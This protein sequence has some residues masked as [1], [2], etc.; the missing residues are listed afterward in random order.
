MTVPDPD[1]LPAELTLPAPSVRTFGEPRFHTEGDLAAVAFAPDDTL[2]SIDEV[3]ALVHWSTAGEV[4]KRAFLSDLETIWQFSADASRL[5]SGK[6]DLLIWDTAAGK[7]A[8][9]VATPT[10]V[11]ALAFTP[12]GARLV[13]G[14]DDG[15]VTVWDA[16]TGTGVAAFTAHPQGV[17]AAS[18]SPDGRHLATAGEDRAVC[19]WDLATRK[20]LHELRSHTDRV[21]SLSWSRDGTLFASAGWDTSA[22]VWRLGESDPVILLNSHAEQVTC[23]AFH[24]ADA[25][26]LATADSDHE[27]YLWADAT[28]GKVGHILRG[29]VDEVRSLAFSRDGKLLASAGMD[30]V[31]HL[32]DAE[33]GKLLAGPNPKGKHDTAAFT[34]NGRLMLGSTGGPTFRLWDVASGDEMKLGDPV[35]AYS[36]AAT[37]DGHRLAVGGTDFVTRL[38]DLTRPNPTPRLLEATKP[39]I[40]SVA[41]H[42]T[43]DLVAHTSPADGLVWLWEATGTE[44]LL[45]LIEAADGC[46]LEGVAFHPD[47]KRVVV[48][49]IDY[50][51]TG[52]RDG[53][54]CVWD[55]E[56]RLKT[57]TF[58]QGVYAVAADPSGRYVAGAGLTDHVYLWDLT[59]NELAFA[60]EGHADKVNAVAFS[61]DGSYL[62][63][64][65]DDQTVRVWD[66]LSGRLLTIREFDVAVQSLSF[67]PD[68]RHLFTGNAN[69]TCH[70]LDFAKLLED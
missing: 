69:T 62:V 36:V 19:V 26:R 8:R 20:K 39:P 68:G 51:S 48:G 28:T 21:P 18:V 54:V 49:G 70:Q 15:T 27:I 41:V 66:V 40:G 55:L 16:A 34:L 57:A 38:Y 13:A 6:D 50:L 35:S 52:E 12:D 59:L 9:R 2:W 61:P 63:S 45:I 37:P 46:T 23:V 31:V 4:L 11:T 30:R 32:W 10:W 58:D 24:P 42:P 17:S 25:R 3:G 47:G 5:A 14:H 43:A 64:A 44:A 29:H 1:Q 56:T 60:L 22:R 53:A 7:L 65:G 67:S 33:A